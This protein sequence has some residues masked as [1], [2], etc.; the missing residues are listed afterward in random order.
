MKSFLKISTFI[1]KVQNT[2]SQSETADFTNIGLFFTNTELYFTNIEL[3]V[4]I[5]NSILP[6]SNCIYQY[7]TVF[8]NTEQYLPVFLLYFV[9]TKLYYCILPILNIILP[10]PNCILQY[11]NEFTNTYLPIFPVSKCILRI[12]NSSLPIT[13]CILLTLNCIFQYWTVFLPIVIYC[14]FNCFCTSM[15]YVNFQPMQL[16][17]SKDLWVS[18]VLAF[19]GA[20][21]TTVYRGTVR[22]ILPNG[23]IEDRT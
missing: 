8:I 13:N 23:A 3:Y 19:S 1:W 4:P 12:L 20:M 7:W 17:C 15:F 9:N 21:G 5:L 22:Y 14:N 10:M 6:I 2:K 16:F 11:W 18:T